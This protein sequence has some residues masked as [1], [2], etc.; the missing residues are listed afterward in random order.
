MTCTAADPLSATERYRLKL[1]IEQSYIQLICSHPFFASMLLHL[2][3]VE[4]W[5]CPTM[6]TDGTRLG[7][8]PQFVLSLPADELRG[9]L[10]HE[11][12]HVASLHPWRRQTRKP[13]PWNVACDHVVND[14]VLEAGFALPEGRLDPIPDTSAEELY[15]DPLG[16]DSGDGAGAGAGEGGEGAGKGN[17]HGD[18][19]DP[20]GCGEVRDATNADGSDMTQADRER[21][22]QEARIRVQQAATAAK[23]RGTLP[24]GLARLVE[25]ALD[26]QVPWKELLSRFIDGNTKHDLS[27]SHPNRR[28]LAQGLIVPGLWSPGFADVLFAADTSGSVSDDDLKQ[29]CTEILACLEL[30]QERG[31][32]VELHMLWCDAAVYPQAISCWDEALRPAGRGGTSFAP[33]FAHIE[34]QELTPRA[35]VFATDGQCDDFGPPPPYPVLWVLTSDHNHRF[36][37]PFGEVAYIIHE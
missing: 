25:E 37:P 19:E 30:Y 31:E 3:R 21:A 2:Q 20:G 24:A 32:D 22:M 1:V 14:I 23:R 29:V 33:V 4:D 5:S 10:A 17:G 28:Y 6:W 7:Y 15:Q 18:S 35:V 16:E 9:V 12:V 26:P 13:K 27:W 8:N 34:E 36:A 11:V